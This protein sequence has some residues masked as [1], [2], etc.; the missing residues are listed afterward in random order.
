MNNGRFQFIAPPHTPFLPNGAL[1]LS[2][3]EKQAFWYEQSGVTGVFVG[4]TT[5]EGQSLT[6]DERIA[7]AQQWVCTS[8]A[9]R[10]K[11]II[12]VGH[13]ELAEARH[14]AAHAGAVGAHAL[15]ATCYNMVPPKN[16]GELAEFCASIAAEAPQLPFYYYHIPEL[17]DVAIPMADFLAAA[18][19]L[20]PN[21]AGVKFT[22]SDLVDLQRCLEKYELEFL[23]GQDESLLAGY[24][25][26][27]HGAI[28]SSY[29]FMAPFYRTMITALDGGDLATARRMQWIATK[30][31]DRMQTV[32]YLPAAK[33]LMRLRGVDCGPARP[34]VA[35][36]SDE[37]L[38]KLIEQLPREFPEC[39]QVD[40]SARPKA[41][42]FVAGTAS[43]TV[44]D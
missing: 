33:R 38:S 21:L 15:A 40:S 3:I 27:A 18:V 28:G 42:H 9:C 41:P 2:A 16:A 22:D 25:L 6:I 44:A 37:A 8:A 26:G 11:V 23:Y 24:V 7:L 36:P 12:H 5:G 1:N 20:I 17:T 30:V 31:I 29:N 10:L 34:P 35:N 39:F 43:R 32:G 13:R 4:G 14:L 19:P